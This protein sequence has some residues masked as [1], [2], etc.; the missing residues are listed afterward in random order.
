[1][2][3]LAEFYQEPRIVCTVLCQK[4]RIGHQIKKP[5][6]TVLMQSQSHV[7][8]GVF[9]PG[10]TLIADSL[11][12]FATAPACSC[13]HQ[14]PHPCYMFKTG[15]RNIAWTCENTAPISKNRWQCSCSCCS[16]AQVG[17]PKVPA[18]CKGLRN[19]LK[20]VKTKKA[21]TAWHYSMHSCLCHPVC[22][23]FDGSIT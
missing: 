7:R 6:T 4:G 19:C 22:P 5:S 11:T 3:L 8:Q 1:M 14:H 15:S 17:Q 16:L 2:N 20:K 9:L 12:M 23:S 21:C 10:L 13:M 18:N